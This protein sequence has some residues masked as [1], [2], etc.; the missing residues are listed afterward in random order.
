MNVAIV[1]AAGACGRQLA[2]Q[3]LDRRILPVTAHLQLVGHHG[4]HS[5]NELWGLVSDLQDAFVDDAPTIDLVIEP[6]DVTAD[7]VVILAGA[8]ISTDPNAPV[9]RAALGRTNHAMFV[10]YAAALAA[11]GGAPPTVI[12]QSNPI[13]LG[14]HVFAEYLGAQHVL[15]AAAWSDTLRLRA[16]LAADLGMRRP[17]VHGWVFGQH[18]DHLVPAW[19]QVRA[20]GVPPDTVQALVDRI[21]EGRQLA[22]MPQ[23]VST[24]KAQMVGLVRDGQARAAYAFV[25]ALP[26]DLRAAVK[27]FFTHFTAGHT[28]EVVTAHAVADLVAALAA[29]EQ[30]VFPAQVALDGEWLGLQ[31]VVGA[32]VVLA[33][34]GWE[35]VYPIALPADEVDAVESAAAAIAAA[36]SQVIAG[37]TAKQ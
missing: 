20:W 36:N 28:T 32:P 16:E 30:R 25:E 24:A 6:A 21:R 33:L 15:G 7:V 13:E 29:G 5:E 8:T 3:L 1:G 34:D 9:D 37:A 31:G 27:P 2:V 35:H 22:G 26:A 10:E 17:Q 4:G 14:V 23:E 12:V 19:S 11:R 18:G